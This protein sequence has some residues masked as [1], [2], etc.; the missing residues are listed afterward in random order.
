MRADV[1]YPDTGQAL[2]Q[3]SHFL[4]EQLPGAT[5]LKVP[6]TSAAARAILCCGEGTDE[7]ESA[8]ICSA[9]CASQYDGLEILVQDIQNEAC[10]LTMSSAGFPWLTLL[11]PHSQHDTLLHSRQLSRS[12]SSRRSHRTSSSTSAHSRREPTTARPGRGT[13]LTQSSDS[14]SD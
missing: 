3:C 8:A 1:R 14:H 12:P 5:L 9:V 2:G 4:S 13:D 6:S 7:P 11:P 10:A